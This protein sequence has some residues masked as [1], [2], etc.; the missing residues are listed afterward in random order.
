MIKEVGNGKACVVIT[1]SEV[2]DLVPGESVV[3]NVK[4]LRPVKETVHFKVGGIVRFF[5]NDLNIGLGVVKQ[6]NQKGQEKLSVLVTQVYETNLISSELFLQRK[7]FKKGKI[8]NWNIDNLEL[9]SSIPRRKGQNPES[10]KKNIERNKKRKGQEYTNSKGVIKKKMVVTEFDELEMCGKKCGRH[11]ESFADQQ[12]FLRNEY[13]AIENDDEKTLYLFNLIQRQ[14]KATST[15]RTESKRQY[16]FQYFLED[17]DK[18]L[19]QVCL[20]MFCKTFGL[21]DKRVRVVREKK[22]ANKPFTT[23]YKHQNSTRPPN[24]TLPQ[25]VTDT[26]EKHISAFPTVP[27]HYCRKD[28]NR[29]YF[30]KGLTKKKMCELYNAQEGVRS[31]SQTK[32]N[33]VLSKFNV[34][35]FKPKKDD[36]SRCTRYRNSPKTKES[37]EEYQAHIMRKEMAREEKER[38]K[39]RAEKDR[40]FAAIIGDLEQVSPCPKA[41]AQEFFYVSKVSCYNYSIYNLGTKDGTCYRWDESKSNRGAN[42]IAS[43]LRHHLTKILTN[44]ITEVVIWADTC[45][46]QNRNK[47]LLALLIALVEDT[48]NNIRNIILKYFEPG[49]S[50]SE[51][52]SIHTTLESAV[53]GVSVFLPT[54]YITIT[55][56]ARRA[57]PYKV[58]M[59]GTDECP[60]MNVQEFSNRKIKNCN[61][62]LDQSGRVGKASWMEAKMIYI[63]KSPSNDE[64]LP[65][66]SIAIMSTFHYDEKVFI[67]DT[68]KR[69]SSKKTRK[70]TRTQLVQPMRILRDDS[71][72]PLAISDKKLKGLLGLVEKN[73]IPRSFHHFYLGLKGTTALTSESSDSDSE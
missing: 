66:T 65:P 7:D 69:P 63:G 3:W 40:T 56:L 54:D 50:Q 17:E 39:K 24:N 53:K 52:D 35:F 15:T 36:C 20:D 43:A 28:S 9:Q 73:L 8:I 32:Y 21:S 55:K 19:K 48:N 2:S 46:G 49:H 12:K 30:E 47:F 70:A 58:V 18:V 37:E 16:T 5:Y 45:G 57:Q 34:S 51:V 41:T 25:C 27:S 64:A 26:I 42:E 68:T 71:S 22:Y 38:D 44:D 31:V 60:V 11:C 14:E 72:E 59:L 61:A 10:W 1:S 29:H 23:A 4:G 6:E 33:E 62:Y 67:I 13:W